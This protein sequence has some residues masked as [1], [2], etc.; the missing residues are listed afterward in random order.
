MRLY[1]ARGVLLSC[2]LVSV[3]IHV[4]MNIPAGRELLSSAAQW[5]DILFFEAIKE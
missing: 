3:T 1:E 4:N 2:L 5:H